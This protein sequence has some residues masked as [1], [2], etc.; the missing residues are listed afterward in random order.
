MEDK[1]T[2][3]LSSNTSRLFSGMT[4]ALQVT[5]KNGT[6][7]QAVADIENFVRDPENDL[8]DCILWLLL[9]H[10]AKSADLDPN[11]QTQAS[12]NYARAL[13][14]KTIA[15]MKGD[16]PFENDSRIRTECKVNPKHLKYM[17]EKSTPFHTA[18]ANGK[19]ELVGD[20]I[21]HF[22]HRHETVKLLD[23]LRRDDPDKAAKYSTALEK[24]A[25]AENRS[26]ETLRALLKHPDISAPPDKTFQTA[27]NGG[28]VAT[29]EEF[30]KH[31]ELHT[32]FVTPENIIQAMNLQLGS[33][34]G[35]P[36]H[37][38]RAKI[39]RSLLNCATKAEFNGEVVR[40]VI[41]LGLTDVWEGQCRG[42]V[43]DTSYLLHLAVVCQNI[44]FVKL[45]MGDYSETLAK[46]ALVPGTEEPKKGAEEQGYYPLWY[47]NKVWKDLK[48]V[49]RPDGQRGSAEIRA[50]LV[51]ETIRT[52]DKLYLLS[53]ILRQSAGKSSVQRI[54]VHTRLAPNK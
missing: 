15:R 13:L 37:E 52:T 53:D 3:E 5:I 17:R 36:E 18:A 11:G 45:F 22:H 47:N 30:L 8:D 14:V 38:A 4:D 35:D 12:E 9:L 46:K 24:A 19:A 10:A 1:F 49:D 51:T 29:V 54:L 6:L 27:L 31:K 32:V 2:K 28:D 44:D 16:L 42:L 50:A 23:I 41:K 25:K 43:L 26:L 40:K 33:N 39:V 34:D 7:E 21:E 48:W 20:M